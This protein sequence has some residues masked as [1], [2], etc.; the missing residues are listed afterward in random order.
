MRGLESPDACPHPQ[1]SIYAART[2]RPSPTSPHSGSSTPTACLIQK[3]GRKKNNDTYTFVASNNPT[4]TPN[5]ATPHRPPNCF[6]FFHLASGPGRQATEKVTYRLFD[7]LSY[8]LSTLVDLQLQMAM[9]QELYLL[10][11]TMR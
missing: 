3:K 8:H 9:R 4:P 7:P 11:S 6:F 1:V 2:S 5:H 10:G